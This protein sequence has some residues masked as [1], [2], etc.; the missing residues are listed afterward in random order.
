MVRKTL[1]YMVFPAVV[2]LLIGMAPIA[3]APTTG[4]V[5]LVV[6]AM[7][8]PDRP[9]D[10]PATYVGATL[11]NY[12]TEYFSEVSYG[13]FS[14]SIKVK[15][16]LRAS[17][18]W[19]E[20]EAYTYDAETAEAMLIEAMELAN[21]SATDYD[22]I[23]LVHSGV[24]SGKPDIV[25]KTGQVGSYGELSY[26]I[27]PFPAPKAAHIYAFLKMMGLS[28]HGASM[29]GW[30]P[31][32]EWINEE[33]PPHILASEKRQLGWLGDD[34][35]MEVAKG[36]ILEVKLSRVS[37]ALGVKAV[38]APL[39]PKTYLYA[40]Y[41]TAEGQDSAVPSNNVLVYLV[42]PVS[43]GELA[44]EKIAT[45][46]AGDVY[47][48]AQLGVGI[49][50]GQVGLAGA[51]IIVSNGLPD[52]RVASI[53]VGGELLPGK[54]AKATITVE[55]AGTATT[56]P[57]KLQVYASGEKIL[58][59]DVRPLEPGDAEKVEVSWISATGD[60]I[61]R[62]VISADNLVD[63]DT[64]NNELEVRVSIPKALVVDDY[65][66]Y[67]SR[68]DVGSSAVVLLHVVR[69]SDGLPAAGAV[70]KYGD[71]EYVV[72]PD[73]WVEISVSSQKV[74]AVEVRPTLVNYYGLEE[75]IFNVVPTVIFD[76]VEIY[77]VKAN[78]TRV[79]VGSYVSIEFKARYAYDKTPFKGR[80]TLN[81]G[82]NLTY[83]D[84]Y[85][86]MWSESEV[87]A[88]EFYVRSVYD[89]LYGLTALKSKS[90]QIIWDKV[91]IT[92]S[93][94]RERINVGEPA[95]ISW[96]AKYAYDEKP[97]RGEVILSDRYP[98]ME[99]VG[100]KTIQVVAIDDGLYGLT[101]FEANQLK[102][103]WD[104]VIVKLSTPYPRV[105]IGT[106]AQIDIYAFYELDGERF[107]GNVRLDSPPTSNTV[108]K[109]I[110]GVAS[111][112][113]SK[114][115]ITAFTSN[116][117]EITFDKILY[118]IIDEQPV[119]GT[120]MFRIK[121][122]YASD[123]EP[124]DAVLTIGNVTVSGRD[125]EYM[126]EETFWGLFFEETANLSVEGFG[127]KELLLS[128]TH[129]SNALLYT[130]AVPVAGLMA[131]NYGRRRLLGRFGKRKVETEVEEELEEI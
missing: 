84:G 19:A 99:K 17:Q 96:V 82:V 53:Q 86:L 131:Y 76:E 125:G 51:D 110:I 124:V 30:T 34:A 9:V 120:V 4:V 46:W 22:Y 49:G 57:L 59:T 16:W 127:D 25:A 8:F 79:D 104:R 87:K 66:V 116:T 64:S 109:K 7:D 39:G 118:K 75:L 42:S 101:T 67:G 13:Y 102:I 18:N 112:S 113:G 26:A 24:W 90:I 5:K 20:Y 29:K 58:E 107:D 14:V 40:E 48:D 3:A 121:V 15:G 94:E 80:L 97:F 126:Y 100:S 83:A 98:V 54:E 91:I 2:A 56:Q 78:G 63:G 85:K 62:A 50:V 38:V 12:F 73:G 72:E 122:W 77:E 45:L 93:A 36:D 123:G 119:P 1:L 6:L 60:N 92:L 115:G 68:F 105:E 47:I 44:A 81:N 130:S 103:S 21:I 89:E 10:T 35:I 117:I 114:Y 111:I 32:A 37:S 70:L 23:M 129:A 33:K 31:M 27:L 128:T 43:G 11:S 71:N 69:D 74:G 88:L 55:N 106:E 65:Q 28:E 108:G 61:V 41:R 52:P 95:K